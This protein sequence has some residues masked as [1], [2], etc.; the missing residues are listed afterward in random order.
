MS[1]NLKPQTQTTRPTTPQYTKT[2][3]SGIRQKQRRMTDTVEPMDVDASVSNTLQL[4]W[5][6]KYRPNKCVAE[7]P[8]RLSFFS[9]MC[10]SNRLTHPTPDSKISSH[11]KILLV[12][13][14]ISLT[15]TI[16]HTSFYT[17]HRAQERYDPCFT[18]LH[19]GCRICGLT[20]LE[21][22]LLRL[23]QLPKK[24]TETKRI[25]AWRWSLT[26]V[27]RVVSM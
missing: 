11:M 5:V 23:L 16:F 15:T 7:P 10:A 27:T 2:S 12:L 21:H 8:L 20:F 25:P 19:Y 4:P 14:R 1:S 22:R 18:R 6:E 13:F 9:V 3:L 24:C 17:A 26:R